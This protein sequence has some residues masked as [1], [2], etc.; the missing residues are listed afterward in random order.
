MTNKIFIATSLDG[1]IADK[2][3]GIDWL[4]ENPSPSGSD[5]GF[6]EF[7]KTV[8]ALVMGR[9][10]YETV[11]SFDCDWPYSKKV[12]VLSNSLN[13]VDPSLKGKAK[14]ING[15]LDAVVKNLNDQGYNNLYIDGGKTIQSFL[16]AGLIDEL[17]ITQIPIV[18]G[19]GFHLFGDLPQRLKLEHCGTKIFDNGMVQSRYKVMR[20]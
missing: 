14:I 3:G 2:N 7:M 18:L 9:T 13:E 10:T 5:G 6:S 19:G 4:H 12:F 20:M 1:Y 8:D 16:K 17:I 15:K 11:L